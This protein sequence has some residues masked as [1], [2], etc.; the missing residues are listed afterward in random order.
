MGSDDF[1]RQTHTHFIIIY[2][3]SQSS[4]NFS[5]RLV[6]LS[7]EGKWYL[8]LSKYGVDYGRRPLPPESQSVNALPLYCLYCTASL[9]EMFQQL[10]KQLYLKNASENCVHPEL[11]RCKLNIQLRVN[12]QV[13][14]AALCHQA[15]PILLRFG[16]DHEK[17]KTDLKLWNLL[18]PI[19][20]W[21]P[22]PLFFCRCSTAEILQHLRCDLLKWA[23]ACCKLQA[24]EPTL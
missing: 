13:I 12:V 20:K 11:A 2:I 18:L 22:I 14:M 3:S 7:Q 24:F 10:T 17:R 6:T 8:I 15:L 16:W 5:S 9:H 4:S 21:S 19:L 23:Q 1:S